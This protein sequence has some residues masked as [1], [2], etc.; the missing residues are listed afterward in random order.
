MSIADL[1]LETGYQPEILKGVEEEKTVPPVSL[2]HQRKAAVVRWRCGPF[3]WCGL[4]LRAAW[5]AG[6]FSSRRFFFVG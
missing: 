3:F 6:R 5:D 1:A 4:T 2:V